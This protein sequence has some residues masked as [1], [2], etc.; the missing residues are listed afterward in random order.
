MG[1]IGVISDIH[2]NVQALQ[3]IMQLFDDERCDEIIHTGDVVDIGPCSRE[4][5]DILLA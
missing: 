3:A 2:G 1:K 5:M 4:C